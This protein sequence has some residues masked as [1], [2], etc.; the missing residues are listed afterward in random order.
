MIIGISGK[1]SS[2]KDTVASIIQYLT[3]KN[4]G[5]STLNK[6]KQISDIMTYEEYFKG[7]RTHNYVE[8]NWEV[9]KFAYKLKQIIS[10]LTG[11]KV[12]DLEDQ[13]FKKLHLPSEW[14]KKTKNWIW[15]EELEKYARDENL[16]LEEYLAKGNHELL[17][18]DEEKRIYRHTHIDE[19][20]TY[21]ELLQKVGTEAMRD[22]VHINVWVNALFTD[23]KSTLTLKDYIIKKLK[24]AS[25][26]ED[27]YNNNKH[28]YIDEWKKEVTPNWIISDLRFPNE[29]K[30]IKDR[31]GVT[32]RINRG[33]QKSEG[34]ESEIA[35]DNAKFDY[36]IDNNGTIEELVE[37]VR[38]ILTLE[39]IL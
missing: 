12:E 26:N 39:K 13:E 24:L 33:E 10:L 16:T 19:K 29:L 9:K 7:M 14:T 5:V 35:L 11:C 27:Y 25:I 34:H 1:I 31:G 28:S 22:R 38:E 3:S 23:Y 30:P 21:R 36:T 2:G 8:S 17:G 37:K 32:I 20:M 6:T 15:E 18:T 4:L